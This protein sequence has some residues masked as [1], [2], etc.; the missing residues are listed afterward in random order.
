[1]IH[2][3]GMLDDLFDLMFTVLVGFF[4]F[5]FLNGVLNAGIDRSH[6]QSLLHLDSFR[7]KDSAINNLNVQ[8]Q[9]G[10]FTD[11]RQIEHRIA[12]SSVLEGRVITSCS[13]YWREHDCVV[14]T[15]K[16]TDGSCVWRDGVCRFQGSR[17]VAG[18]LQ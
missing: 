18:R 17:T 11:P 4:L 15:M 9:E 13:D 16:V 12:L 5:F 14:D 1:M 8:V 7:V 6:D 3:K 2:K 10:V